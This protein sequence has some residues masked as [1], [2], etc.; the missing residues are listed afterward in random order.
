MV[1]GSVDEVPLSVVV[2]VC[3]VAPVVVCFVP[4]VL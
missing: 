4:I 3:A 1:K 2:S